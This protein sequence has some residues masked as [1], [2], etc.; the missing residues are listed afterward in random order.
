MET[1][2][3]TMHITPDL[4]VYIGIIK[5]SRGD[6]WKLES[7]YRNNG[8]FSDAIGDWNWDEM[9]HVPVESGLPKQVA[10]N[11]KNELI[12]A[13]GQQALNTR[14]YTDPHE[15]DFVLS[16]DIPNKKTK[17][18]KK[19]KK[20]TRKF[21]PISGVKSELMIDTRYRKNDGRY[22]VVIRVYNNGKYAYL[23]TGY[24]MTPDEFV[25]MEPDTER[26]MNVK[27]DIV[28][29][30]I[31]DM[32]LKGRFDIN[33]IKSD[34]ERQMSGNV[35]EYKTLLGLLEEKMGMLDNPHTIANYRTVGKWLREV[36]PDG[37]PLNMISTVTIGKFVSKLKDSGLNDTTLNIYGTII[38][39]TINYGIY[40]GVIGSDQYPFRRH[41][42]EVDK[43]ALPKSEKRDMEYLTKEQMQ[44]VWEY[45]K[46]TKNR[47]IGYF[48]FS[49]LHGGLNLADLIC[50]KFSD[51][52]FQ[53]H[54]FVYK[55]QKTINKNDFYVTV[56]ATKWTDELFAIMGIVP[57]RGE[58]VFKDMGYNGTKD[59]YHKTK[60]NYTISTNR[61]ITRMANKLGLRDTSMTTARH[62]FCTIANK[63]RMPYSMIERCM[64]H[65]NNGV[66]GHYIGG[67]TIDEMRPDFERLL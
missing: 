44:Q 21:L 47:Y 40:K 63:Q 53:E 23:Q 8:K 67:F 36:Y 16:V 5:D 42:V 60:T 30:Y 55:R 66:S 54:A 58:Y 56:P 61:A 11:M 18:M 28:L 46:T 9:N 50:L 51:L 62:T 22:A 35:V 52:W 14:G 39:S 64:G 26:A 32:T 37:L 4:K 15:R 45:F 57:K 65:A 6:R 48:L 10:I 31:K 17:N 38:K 41:A 20:E 49:Y 34:L 33:A 59:S 2:K 29:D 24:N 19:V 27:R 43:V 13:A 3:V 12:K 1:Y 25:G 7:S